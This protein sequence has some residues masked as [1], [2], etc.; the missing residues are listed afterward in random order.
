MK[1]L[2]DLDGVL[3]DW[4]EACTRIY[5]DPAKMSHD[6]LRAVKYD[7]SVTDFYRNLKPIKEGVELFLEMSAAGETAILTSV[8]KFNSEDVAQQK[9]DALMELFGYV[10]EFHYTKSSKDK[11]AY[12]GMG[13]LVDDRMKAVAPFRAA[14]GSAVLFTG[15]KDAAMCQLVSDL[16]A[17]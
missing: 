16:V 5:G 10:P 17:A 13:V 4:V 11:A 3:F 6:Q 8:G 14:G 12:A 2:F 15:S 1:T 7:M 9:K